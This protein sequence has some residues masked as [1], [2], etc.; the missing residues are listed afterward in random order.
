[1]VKIKKLP[2][3]DDKSNKEETKK[4]E[5][6]EEAEKDGGTLSDGVLDAF[7]EVALT[8][9]LAEEDTLATEDDDDEIDSGDY[10]ANDEW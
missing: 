5:G 9:P 10:K 6:E 2:V 4:P 3:V 1:M 8:D 7:E